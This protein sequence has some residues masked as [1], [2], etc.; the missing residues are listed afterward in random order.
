M[1][2]S[3]LTTKQKILKQFSSFLSSRGKILLLFSIILLLAIIGIAVYSEIRASVSEKS[4]ILIEELEEKYNPEAAGLNENS[5]EQKKTESVESIIASLDDIIA[6]YSSY[7]AGQRALYMKGTIY[8]DEKQYDKA[9]ENFSA[10]ADKY[11]KSY[12]APISLHNIAVCYEELGD[13]DSS[14]SYYKKI[15]ER[16]SNDYPNI[17]HVLFSLGRLYETKEEFNTALEYYNML[18]DKYTDSDWT[19]FSK[20]RIIYLKRAGKI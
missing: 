13:I 2:Q 5:D 20:D 17:T 15:T 18:G 8:F 14:I 11:K 16:Y 6:K 10:V 9:V 7:Y 19:I 3:A 4:T 12:L 1:Q